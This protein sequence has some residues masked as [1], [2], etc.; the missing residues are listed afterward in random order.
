MPHPRRRV[1]TGHDKNGKSIIVS[2]TAFAAG[3]ANVMN[4]PA[5]SEFCLTEIW[6]IARQPHVDDPDGVAGKPIVFAPPPGG[7]TVKVCELPSEHKRNHAERANRY[8]AVGADHGFAENL[9]RHPAMHK[10]ESVDVIVVISGRMRL[11]MDEGETLL[12]PS[13]VVIQRGTNHAWS[14]PYEEPC[15]FAAVLVDA[16][17]R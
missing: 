6:R 14:N 17:P 2:D 16:T 4:P 12:G 9:Q 5:E 3:D 10:T 11:I 8:A 15:V 13:D 7:V 1:V